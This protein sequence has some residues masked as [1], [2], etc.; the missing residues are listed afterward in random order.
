MLYVKEQVLNHIRN[1][2]ISSDVEQGFILGSKTRLNQLDCCKEI[3]AVQ[4]SLNI[5]RANSYIADQIISQWFEEKTCICGFLHSHVVDKNDLS[6]ADKHFA[7][8]L[9][10]TYH[11]PL[12]WFGLAVVTN[13]EVTI[14]FYCVQEKIE[15]NII[16]SPIVYS[17][18]Y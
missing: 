4:A 7:T 15:G 6:E 11:L 10:K 5:Y 13:N 12:F 14:S 9:Y 3:P 2:V 1:A 16:V 18:I 8:M 17:I